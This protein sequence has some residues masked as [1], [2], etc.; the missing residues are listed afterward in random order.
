M[1]HVILGSGNLGRDLFMEAQTIKGV[2]P[3][4]YS[5]SKGFDVTDLKTVLRTMDDED[6]DVIWY[7]VGGGMVA[8][9]KTS[10]PSYDKAVQLNLNIPTVLADKL[11]PHVS[12]VLF[13]SDYAADETRPRA[14]YG[15]TL[16]PRCEYA[17]HKLAMEQIIMRSQ[18]PLTSIVRVG[19]L[20]GLHKPHATFPGKI[21]SKFGF[22]SKTVKLP[23][24]IVTPTPTR[25]L[26][27]MLMRNFDQ[28][29]SPVGTTIEHVAPSGGVT[30]KDWAKFVLRGLRDD[31]AFDWGH[32]HFDESRP[33]ISDLGCT[34]GNERPIHWFELWNNY[35][36]PEWFVSP[37]WRDG[38]PAELKWV[39]HKR[40]Y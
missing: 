27:S 1:K 17:E 8:E 22:N 24:N 25:W 3:R 2:I 34:L 37:E 9:S 11:P 5:L 28:L 38:I 31:S 13:S 15:C 39:R 7:C 26:A 4:I 23:S 29:C 12:L 36:N 33:L 40:L 35:F 20:Y 30:I 6:P 18:R 16:R 14:H 21:L 32:D 10:S 19:S